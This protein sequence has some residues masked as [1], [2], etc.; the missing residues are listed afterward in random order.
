[1]MT[2]LYCSLLVQF[3]N[4]IRIPTSRRIPHLC[5]YTN[6][7][8]LAAF[9]LLSQ[10]PLQKG[11]VLRFTDTDRPRF[12]SGKS[13]RTKRKDCAS[14]D[15]AACSMSLEGLCATEPR[16][17]LIV[18]PPE[19]DQSTHHVHSQSSSI[20]RLKCP[21]NV[22]GLQSPPPWTQRPVDDTHLVHLPIG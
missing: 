20:S 10:P 22:P 4:G 7:A 3:S 8:E 18:S 17:G 13:K 1:M 16:R 6:G 14:K 11:K 9:V 2:G 12:K 21:H 5:P 15:C 19:P